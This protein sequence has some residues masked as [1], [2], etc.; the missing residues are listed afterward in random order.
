[1]HHLKVLTVIKFRK[2]YTVRLTNNF[3]FCEGLVTVNDKKYKSDFLKCLYF[4]NLYSSNLIK[5]IAM[6]YL[7]IQQQKYS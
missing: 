5:N 4:K 7:I 6:R 2:C 1:M 3:N